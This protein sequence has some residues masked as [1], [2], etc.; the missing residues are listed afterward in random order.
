M[1]SRNLRIIAAASFF[2][3]LLL[4]SAGCTSIPG[5]EPRI[6]PTPQKTKVPVTPQVKISAEKTTIPP[7]SVV[8]A[9]RTILMVTPSG[10]PQGTYES[11][12]CVQQGGTVVRPGEMCDGTW[13]DATDTFSCCSQT[14]ASAIDRNATITVEPFDLE[15]AMDDDPGSILP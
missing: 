15:I 4:I 11:R 6:T 5:P 9:V 14:P 10:T 13:L 7:T 8:T 2:I 3:L 12:T 1:T